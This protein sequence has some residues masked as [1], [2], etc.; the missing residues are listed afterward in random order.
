MEYV[1]LAAIW[2]AFFFIHSL[3]AA[4]LVKEWFT[5]IGMSQR[6][7]RLV[8]SLLSTILFLLIY[9]YSATLETYLLWNFGKG[10]QY[11][12]MIVATIGIMIVIRS[13][14][15]FSMLS[16]IGLKP[17][18]E[19]GLVTTGLHA[20]VRHPIYSGTLVILFG[21]VLFAPALQSVILLITTCI[22]LPFGIYWEEQKLK[23]VY[24]E[25]YRAYI[26]DVP[27]LIP[28]FRNLSF[29]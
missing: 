2:L 14:K 5:G 10:G 9:F 6:F 28:R 13:F 12:G 3:L 11:V 22:Y 16:F 26:Q 29:L 4:T 17:E 1:I 25:A 20:W 21:L 18:K 8:Y 19:S 15:K 23:S 24:G 7:Y 27:A